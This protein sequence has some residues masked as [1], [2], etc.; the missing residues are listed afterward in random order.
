MNQTL[1]KTFSKH[2]S[3][4]ILLSA[5]VISAGLIRAVRALLKSD[6][7]ER[8]ETIARILSI[9][10]KDAL[11]SHDYATMQRY[12]NEIAEDELIRS[13]AVI[14][15]DGQ[16]LAGTMPWPE[17]GILLSEHPIR[18]GDEELGLIRIGFSTASLD[19]ITWWIVGA[20][21]P[22]ALAL[23]LI[24]LLFT[25]L[26]LKRIVISPLTRLQKAI[27]KVADGD[28]RQRIARQ[29]LREFDEISTTFNEMAD[30]LQNTIDVIAEHQLR[31]D[32]EKQKLAAIVGC[33]AD[34]LFVTDNEGKITLFNRAAET[35]TGYNESESLGR[36]CS[37]LFRSS[38]SHDACAL[39]YDDEARYNIESCLVN[40]AGKALTVAVSCAMLRD[41]EGRRIGEVQTFRDISA[42]KRRHEL[43]C[44]TEKLAA[45]G[46]L[47]AGVAHEIKTPLGNIIGYAGLIKPDRD[48]ELIARQVKIIIEQA[49][50]CSATVRGLLDYARISSTT[51]ALV[52][53]NATVRRVVE[54]LRLQLAKK[55]IELVLVT[56]HLPTIYTDERKVEQ[57][58][59]NLLMNAIQAVEV[60][61]RIKMQTWST[62]KR[63]LLN[64]CDSGPGIPEE[65]Q[66]RIF[67]PFFTT[68]PLG[69]GTGLGLPICAGII[70]ELHGSIDLESDQS[71]TCFTV[72]IPINQES[73]DEE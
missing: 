4:I 20:T 48:P 58:A 14:S 73:G 8:G 69:E 19:I 41:A 60:G 56:A 25:S 57:V 50:K 24:G 54:M 70:A 28:L 64:I 27:K 9:V 10:T 7:E 65:M 22:L 17:P 53:L 18:I 23:H 61:G 66:N 3:V 33:M 1:K 26:V 12:T 44:W 38:L 31:L 11:L 51:P 52:D 35:I 2:L 21:V 36:Q 6:L 5:V 29:G 72:N 71:G 62:E 39:T 16:L 68:K 30:K 43:Y 13:I 32:V 59:M 34:G 63:V 37:E 46:Q 47:A 40:K 15:H 45:T 42:E 67:D 55:E 49:H